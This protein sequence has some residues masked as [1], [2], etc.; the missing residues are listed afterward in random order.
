[1]NVYSSIIHNLQKQKQHK[2]SEIDQGINKMWSIHK[3]ECHSAIKRNELLMSA[4]TWMNPENMVLGEKK[5]TK[6]HIL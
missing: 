1:M 3:M 4:A 6:G 5:D 2:H